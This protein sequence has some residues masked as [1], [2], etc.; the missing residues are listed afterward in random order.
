MQVANQI[1]LVILSYILY[2]LLVSV[3]I[4]TVDDIGI[5]IYYASRLKAPTLFERLPYV[6]GRIVGWAPTFSPKFT[7]MLG[8]V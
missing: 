3:C 4:C 5:S 1:S 6:R 2:I 7:P 8:D